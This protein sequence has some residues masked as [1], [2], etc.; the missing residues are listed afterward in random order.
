MSDIINC[1]K[2]ET[3]GLYS[4][5][6]QMPSKQRTQHV[7]ELLRQ[8]Q[9][10]SAGELAEFRLVVEKSCKAIQDIDQQISHTEQLLKSL[11]QARADTELQRQDA[12]SLLHPIRSLPNE[13]IAQIFSNCVHG[14][15]KHDAWWTVDSLN[16]SV[17]PWTLTRVCSRWRA[18]ALAMPELWTYIEV[19]LDH[20]ARLRTSLRMM[21]LYLERSQR[22]PLFVRLAGSAVVDSSHPIASL[23]ESAASRFKK[24]SLNIH[25]LSLQCFSDTYF[26][27]LEFLQLRVTNWRLGDRNV[28][29]FT[30]LNAPMLR[31]F[32]T[33]RD[34]SWSEITTLPWSQFT[35]MLHFSAFDRDELVH[36]PKMANLEELDAVVDEQ[37]E[38][39][40]EVMHLPN[41]RRLTLK[42]N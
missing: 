29:P 19:G 41:L 14:W 4:P 34:T 23:L 37:Y 10:P 3:C 18:L 17:A 32:S 33:H 7:E 25:S 9:S 11:R 20:G 38:T 6:L 2:C 5:V 35:A 16:Y 1:T 15:E 22:L 40:N 30:S 12:Q 36:L 24:L 8:T 13:I 21:S 27:R 39:I 42:E 26:P 31:T 28:S